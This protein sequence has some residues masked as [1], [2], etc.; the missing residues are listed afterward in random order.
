MVVKPYTEQVSHNTRTRK[1]STLIESDELVWHRDATDREVHVLE[2]LG[3]RFQMD[4]E[5]P[6]TLNPGDVIHIPRETYHRIIKGKTDL[7]VKIIDK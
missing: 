5:L 1:F 6:V 7:T 2:G 3:W 4:N